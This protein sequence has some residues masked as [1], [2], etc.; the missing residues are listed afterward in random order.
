MNCD[1]TGGKEALG[2]GPID[3][4]IRP[5]NAQDM[6]QVADLYFPWSS[7]QDTHA[8]WQKYYKEQQQ[9]IR[10]VAGIEKNAQILGYGNLLRRSEYPHFAN[11]PEISDAWIYEEHRKQGHGKRLILWLEELACREGYSR[12]GIGVGLYKD[13]GV[14]QQLYFQLGYKPD[15]RGITYKHASVV[16]GES[17]PVDDDLIFWLT[18]SLSPL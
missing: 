3:I 13:Y 2:L 11:I 12:I 15:G 17:Y 6:A 14:A 9:N 10:T 4:L 1:R 8:K 18:K 16:S 5:M 7:R